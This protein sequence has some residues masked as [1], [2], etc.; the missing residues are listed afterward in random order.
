MSAR[1]KNTQ[2]FAEKLPQ[3]IVIFN[4][5]GIVEWTNQQTNLLFSLE[6]NSIQHINQLFDTSLF[7]LFL[8]DKS[9]HKHTI[10]I[11]NNRYID[12][13]FVE[14]NF[15]QFMVVIDDT[16]H[17]HLLEIMRRDFIANVSHELRTPLTVLHGFLENLIDNDFDSEQ[18]KKIYQTMFQQSTRMERL[19]SD[20]LL[21]SRLETE[22]TSEEEKENIHIAQ[23]IENIT[24]EAKI[25]SGSANH[26]I[27][28]D[29]QD[30]LT[31]HGYESELRSAFSNLIF[32]AVKYTPAHGEINI[33]WRRENNT[34][35]F[36]V[37]DS[38]IGIAPQHI[39]RLTER[40]YRVD[41]ARSRDKGGTG[42][43][44]AIVK[45]VLLRHQG[46]LLITSDLG[47]GSCFRCEFAIK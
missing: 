33:F 26:H 22:S 31:L 27:V 5:Y 10:Y 35:I 8:Q 39:P 4:D 45:H 13:H 2:H 32:N 11:K 37:R 1:D 30:D 12:I 17:L 25:L 14:L 44:L 41:K 38:G 6:K 7:H 23:L 9:K 36:E 47:C 28:T 16:T 20:L 46:L 21:L 15:E 3:A 18:S 42:L 34:A 29:L 43:G 24:L 19:I 40:F